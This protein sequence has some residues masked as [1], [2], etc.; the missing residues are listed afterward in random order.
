MAKRQ[1][2]VVESEGITFFF[3]Y[4]KDAPDILHIYVR[5]LTE[6]D[7]A[8]DVFFDGQSTWNSKHERFETYNTTHGLFWFWL[9]QKERK[10]MVITCFKQEESSYE[11]DA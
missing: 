11:S 9:N 6:I 3:A 8:L 2:E 7:D 1:Y 5:H 4:D 10:V